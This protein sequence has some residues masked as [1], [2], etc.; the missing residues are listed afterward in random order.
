MPC[1]KI[2]TNVTLDA[3]AAKA[4]ALKLAS[5]AATAVG[6]PVERI[7]TIIEPGMA[8]TYRGVDALV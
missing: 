7:L 3:A 8:L 5:E 6:K 4:K 1:I 2:E